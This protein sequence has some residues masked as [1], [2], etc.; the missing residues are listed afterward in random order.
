VVAAD[1]DA[2]TRAEN[3]SALAHDDLAAGYGL[4]CEDLYAKSLRL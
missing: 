4:A 1:A 2:V 3:G